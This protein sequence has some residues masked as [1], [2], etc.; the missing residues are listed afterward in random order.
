MKKSLIS[1][2][3]KKAL[4]K[5]RAR[6]KI[7]PSEIIVY[8]TELPNTKDEDFIYKIL[9]KSFTKFS[10]EFNK[11]L[12][13]VTNINVI[14]IDAKYRVTFRYLHQLMTFRFEYD[15]S[16]GIALSKKLGT[17]RHVDFVLG[18]LDTVS[19]RL[20]FEN[21]LISELDKY[22]Q[23]VRSE[24]YMIEVLKDLVSG[25]MFKL[26]YNSNLDNLGVDM[27][28]RFSNTKLGFLFQIK[29][30]R[31][32]S[33]KEF[34]PSVVQLKNKYIHERLHNEL[35][36]LS[37]QNRHDAERHRFHIQQRME[38]FLADHKSVA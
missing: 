38:D 34:V 18:C 12:H 31:K 7:E 16:R 26:E 2:A 23:G 5:Y 36:Y 28:M 1:K 4:Q 9:S 33:I 15:K 32:I 11:D 14:K 6:K 27:F 24:W 22:M 13:T 37:I 8:F 10:R 29:K 19:K 21:M 25:T 30:T 17:A 20:I 3:R 35:I